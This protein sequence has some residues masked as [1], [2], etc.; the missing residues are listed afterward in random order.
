MTTRVWA[1]GEFINP[2]DLRQPRSSAPVVTNQLLN[3]GFE[4]GN[5]T[6]WSVGDVLITVVAGPAFEGTYSLRHPDG[7]LGVYE[8]SNSNVVPVV[9]G[10]TIKLGCR[11]RR[12]TNVS[13]RQ[14][15]KIVLRWQDASHATLSET[16]FE[17]AGG[18]TNV[19]YDPSVTGV[20][21]AGAAFVKAVLYTFQTGTGG[22]HHQ[23]FDN[24]SWDYV[25]PVAAAGLVY[26]AVQANA[27]FTAATEPVWPTVLGNT[28]V[29]N[30]VTWEA[31]LASNVTWEATPIL[32]SGALEPT[33]P[34]EVGATVLDGTVV[35]KAISRRVSDT[36]CP[37]SKV[38]M[39]AA[40]K[41]FA[42]D[43]DIIGF[44]ATVNP[45]DWSTPNDAGYLPFGLQTYGAN[46]VAVLGL[47]RANLVA[48]NSQ[49]FQMWQVDQDPANMAFLD[50]VPVGS[51]YTHTWVPVAND[52]VGLTSVGVRNL[53]IA[54]ASTNLQADGVG[55][56]IDSLVRPA[57]KLLDSDD[58]VFSLFWPAA[59]QHWT[60]FG[61]E[62]FVLTI[63]AAKKK[64]WSR[65]VFPEDVVAFTLEGNTLV[66]RLESGKIL[67]MSDE[68][69]QD[70]VYTAGNPTVLSG[71][72]NG[73]NNDLSWTAI[74]V[75]GGPA[76]HH[77]DVYRAVGPGSTT[78]VQI[79]EV[80]AADPLELTD[81][82]PL[83]A[84]QTYNYQVL[85]VDVRQIP[86]GASNTVVLVAEADPD[87]GDIVVLLQANTGTL[88]EASGLPAVTVIGAGAIS[89]VQSKFGGFSFYNPGTNAQAT[90]Y[91]RMEDATNGQGLFVLPGEF[92]IEG[93]FYIQGI[94]SDVYNNLFASSI[95]FPT[96]GFIQLAFR[97]DLVDTL[98]WNSSPGTSMLGNIPFPPGQWVFLAVSRDASNAI[99]FFQDGVQVGTIT[100]SGDIG[101]LNPTKSSLDCG[102]G[103]A[104]DN[105]DANCYFDQIRVTK[106]CRYTANFSPPTAPF[107]TS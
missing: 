105:A 4:T 34:V 29:D 89:A 42:G 54:G 22:S 92:T 82:G 71:V 62:A 75:E 50:A 76:I 7:L 25:A 80:A 58:D 52:L 65:Y 107:P 64:S 99:R 84:G 10:Q 16:E 37:N 48:F 57:V 53:S 98:S 74:N 69:L 55:E 100:A 77:Y 18:A 81:T 19:W 66:L 45:L 97:N 102:R 30:Q 44:S 32:L 83:V 11:Y 90:N 94:N 87:F 20:A 73:G 26:K 95:N 23:Y 93:W 63:N 88:V 67:D 8:V 9:P 3:P 5:L 91:V 56:P 60:I 33:F 39:I 35:W 36:R 104:S 2:G 96:L 68:A 106:A 72:A 46:P 13:G 27:G 61:D 31:V 49:G 41:V 21:P 59:G 103:N 86:G 6:N 70:E 78:F 47:Y 85:G 12:E 79:G 40:S 51:T 43:G 1:P 28:V 17:Q 24:F 38:V 101:A 15:M 14:T